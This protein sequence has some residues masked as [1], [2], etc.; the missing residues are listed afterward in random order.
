MCRFY[1]L[2]LVQLKMKIFCIGTYYSMVFFESIYYICSV[3]RYVF[4]SR[5]D[6]DNQQPENFFKKIF[7]LLQ[8]HI[9]SKKCNIKVSIGMVIF[10]AIFPF[11]CFYVKVINWCSIGMKKPAKSSNGS[12]REYRRQFRVV[13]EERIKLY[14]LY[15]LGPWRYYDDQMLRNI[16]LLLQNNNNLYK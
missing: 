8:P 2:P 13:Y 12:S 6:L 11:Y 7:V 15:S 5:R 10:K 9:R 16:H 3:V 4:T 1:I 14:P